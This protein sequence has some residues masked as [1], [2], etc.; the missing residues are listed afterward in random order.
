MRQLVPHFILNQYRSG[1]FSGSL[2]AAGLF[3][4]LSGFSKM[5]DILF[6][7]E[8]PGAE[9]LA[10]VVRIIF[11]PMVEAVYSQGG[12]VVGYSGDAFTAIFTEQQDRDPAILRCLDAAVR[13]QAYVRDHPQAETP[14][15][16]YPISVRVGISYGEANWNIL[17]S[18]NGKQATYYIHGSSVDGAVA[19]EEN[20]GP[21]EI[22]ADS[23]AYEHLKAIVDGQRVDECYRLSNVH[24][25]LPKPRSISDPLPASGELGVFIP[26]MVIHSP[27][28][29]EFRQIVNLFIDIPI[30]PMDGSVVTSFMDVVFKLQERYG[31]Y[32][33]RPEISDKGFNLLMFWGAP[34]A[35][36]TDIDR[37]LNFVL[38]LKVRSG[39]PIRAGI[40]YLTSYAG[41]IGALL[42]ED[43][44]AYGWGVNLA[45]RFMKMS[46]PSEVWIDEEVARRA[47]RHFEVKYQDKFEFKGFTRKQ[48][49]FT[50][51]G[52]KEPA[53]LVFHGD[54]IGRAQELR[55][56]S[57]FVKPIFNGQFVGVLVIQGEAGIGKSRLVHSFQASDE[58]RENPAHWLICQTDEILRQSLNPFKG[59]LFKRFSVSESQSETTNLE[60]FNT[61]LQTLIDATPVSFLA[62]ELER[63]SSVLAALL[64]ISQQDSLYEKLDAK[65]RYENTFIALSTLLRAESLQMPL[66]LFLEDI[67]WLDDDTRAFLPYFV[68]TVSVESDITYPIAILATRRPYSEHLQ[69]DEVLKTQF[70]TLDR[71]STNDLSQ[72]AKYVLGIPISET[73]LDLLGRRTEG[74]P[75]FAEQILRYLLEKKL[76]IQNRDG[77]FDSDSRAERSLPMDVGAVLISRLDSLAPDVRDVAQTASILGR[78]FE[79][80]LLARMLQGD[81]D[82][83]KKIARAENAEIW[84]PL[85]QMRY[86]FRHALLRDAAYSMQLLTRQ[87]ELHALAVSSMETLYAH[88][89]E[90]HYGELAYHAQRANLV[91]KALVYLPLAGG[92]AASVYQNR[93][94][95]DYFSRAIALT[96]SNNLHMQFEL[97][98]SRAKLYGLMGE[99]TFQVQDLDILERLSLQLGQDALLAQIWVMRADYSYSTSK[100]QYAI[101]KARQALNLAK[102]AEEEEVALDAYRVSSLAFLRQG[103]LDDA[104]Q[105]AE[106]GL[107]IVRRLGRRLE[108]G[109]ILNSMG[110]IALEQ[111]EPANAQAYFEQALSIARE[112]SNRGLET[113]SLN[114]LGTSTG[115]VQGDY[116][117]AREYYE[118]AYL[119]ARERGDR[120]L[121]SAALGNLG[122]AAGMQ[123][124]FSSA[125]SYH[126]QALLLAREVG[127]LY[128]EAY[129]LVNLSAVAIQQKEVQDAIKYA[130]RANELSN[131]IGDRPG[132]AWSL[133]YLGNA[134]LL[135]KN[136]GLAR[137]AFLE[138]VTIRE[139]LDQKNLAME[140][141]AGLIH[142]AL[143]MNDLSV[144]S[145]ETEKILQHLENGGSFEGAE[146]PLRIYC[147]CFQALQTLKDPRSE[148][149][150]QEAVKLLEAQVSRLQDAEARQMFIQNVPCRR[151]INEAWQ[152]LQRE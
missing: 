136:T 111:K 101:E 5:A 23:L 8:Q 45:A 98:L 126:E 92:A 99:R 122:W 65:E 106:E 94:A 71:L 35:H 132:A 49:V 18:S 9:T 102:S 73:L 80:P 20:A 131:K 121:Q 78:E 140:P 40:T 144:V 108:E 104:L 30:D 146:E 29:G 129:T 60:N 86:I 52:R 145:S 141:I 31:G 46:A 51:I 139:E 69:L 14:F 149:I 137:D 38:D 116:A 26:E 64:G 74:N 128:H 130:Q 3:I 103:R 32:F 124:D 66:I 148:T 19:A 117:A 75:F 47:E 11:E 81:S 113:K 127:D 125:R 55:Q 84:F 93:Q 85:D 28:V 33:L 50:L 89:L 7:Y 27:I 42:R 4:D 105:H 17:K 91:E 90:S 24:T 110:L 16:R 37:A 134:Y 13:M 61:R 44:T 21:G 43:Y 58:F 107:Q 57:T 41:F 77:F 120:S 143:E 67:Q 36:E 34:I 138:A 2:E 53:D 72:L 147:A 48:K 25:E 123:G 87:R 152:N 82:L 10:E 76:L 112:S 63:T 109:K 115:F 151:A 15:G 119:I 70:L 133:L 135:E 62:V 83:L 1:Q 114:N 68:R 100:Y 95:V 118:Q 79:V 6:G 96:P 59:W 150:L 142:V 54:L 56:L 97:H 39:L 88:E 12:F 22:L